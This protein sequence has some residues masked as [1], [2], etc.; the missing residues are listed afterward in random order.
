MSIAGHRWFEERV[1]LAPPGDV[2]FALIKPDASHDQVTEIRRMIEEEGLTIG[3]ER[4]ATLTEMDVRA[5]Y[6]AHI[7]KDF[8]ARN[9]E[10]MMSRESWL[11]VLSGTNAQERWRHHLMPEIR[12]RWLNHNPD[13]RHRN[14]VHGSDS[15]ENAFRELHYFFA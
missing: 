1:L 8:Y 11:M 9:A 13:A 6:W 12:Q 2:T 10:F 15:A 5:L 7:G 3:L 14:L 4:V